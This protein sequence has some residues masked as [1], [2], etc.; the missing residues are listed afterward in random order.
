MIASLWL[1]CSASNAI[2][3]KDSHGSSQEAPVELASS[4]DEEQDSGDEAASSSCEREA[5]LGRGKRK[6]ARKKKEVLPARK[7]PGRNASAAAKNLREASDGEAC[8]G[9]VM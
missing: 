5:E 9:S 3:R 4:S 7:Q 1:S 8:Q 2:K 6:P